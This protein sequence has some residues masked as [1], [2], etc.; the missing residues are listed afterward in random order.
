MK[1]DLENYAEIIL[2]ECLKLKKEEPLFIQAP[3]ER[4]D[5]VRIV[6]NKAYEYG[7]KDIH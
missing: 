3:L 7:I 1:K 2:F 6:C 5:F 4:Y